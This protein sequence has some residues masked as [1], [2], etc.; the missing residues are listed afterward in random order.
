MG[1]PREAIRLHDV[2]HP[3]DETTRSG[4]LYCALVIIAVVVIVVAARHGGARGADFA[5]ARGPTPERA[6]AVLLTHALANAQP[7]HELRPSA[8]DGLLALLLLLLRRGV[9]GLPVCL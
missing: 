5:Q 8:E 9:L 2:F 3:R 4:G 1:G 6:A 7:L